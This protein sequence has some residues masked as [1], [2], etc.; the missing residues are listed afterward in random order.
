MKYRER[1]Y[2]NFEIGW[3][4]RENE[5]FYNNIGDNFFRQLEFRE[6]K[7]ERRARGDSKA[8]ETANNSR[9]NAEAVLIW[10]NSSRISLHEIKGVR[11]SC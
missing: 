9:D 5:R 7:A 6:N 11:S 10:S 3:V 2:M 1:K 4:I 8:A